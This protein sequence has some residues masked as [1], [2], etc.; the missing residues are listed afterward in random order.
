VITVKTTE[1]YVGVRARD[2]SGKVLGTIRAI[3]AGN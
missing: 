3:E 2:A 1:P